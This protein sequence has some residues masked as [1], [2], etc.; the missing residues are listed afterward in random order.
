MHGQKFK[1]GSE[2]VSLA[3]VSASGKSTFGL[4]ECHF[5]FVCDLG[6][7]FVVCDQ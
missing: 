3:D 4:F 1:T 6:A 5:R 2:A 7:V